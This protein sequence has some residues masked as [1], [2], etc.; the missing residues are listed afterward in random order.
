MNWVD[1]LIIALVVGS[2]LHGSFQGAAVQVL[3]YLGFGLGLIAG[4]RLGP[5]L[6]QAT[7]NPVLKV[8]AVTGCLFGLAAILSSIGRAIGVR[9]TWGVLNRMK[10]GWLNSAVGSGIAIVATLLTAWL[11]GGLLAQVGLPGITGG[12]HESKIMQVLDDRLPPAPAVFSRVQA[13]LLPAGFPPVFAGLEPSPAPAVPVTAGPIVD[14]AVAHAKASTVKVISTGCGRIT[15]GSGF[16]VGRGLVVTNAHVVA[17]VDHPAVQDGSGSHRASVL[18]FDPKMDLAVLQTTGL[19]GKALLLD[20]DIVARGDQGAVLGYPQGGPFH[21]EPGA[22]R[23]RL[24]A[25][26]GR[27]IY[28]GG[29]VSR[30]VY[31][32]EAQVKPGNS[33]GPFVEE[34]GRVVGVV[35]ASSLV[36]PNV[37][38]ALTSKAVGAQVDKAGLV[39]SPMGS[40]RCAA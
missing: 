30:D 32:L 34:S 24:P 40:G 12:F 13:A 35:F 14:A 23:A 38:Y 7:N 20:R 39:R 17:G 33:G 25:V 8:A 22:V 5:V 19:A 21:A 28:A 37:A 2:A 10:L 6:A 29:L 18:L 16:V 9:T 4:A 26:V 31:Q 1:L 36:E 3:S 11:I 15:L 27:D